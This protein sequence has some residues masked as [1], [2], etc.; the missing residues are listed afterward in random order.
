MSENGKKKKEEESGGEVG[1]W[2]V[3]FADMITLLLSFFVMLTTFSSYSKEELNKFSGIW[4]QLADYSVYTGKQGNDSFVRPADRYTDFTL[5]GSEKPTDHDP[6]V[7]SE[8][9]ASEWLASMSDAYSRRRVLRIP[10]TRLFWG[11]DT[12][13]TVLTGSGMQRMKLLAEFLRQVPCQVLIGNSI[14][15]RLSSVCKGSELDRPMA[16]LEYLRNSELIPSGRIGLTVCSP[17]TADAAGVEGVIEITLLA[18][19]QNK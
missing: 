15:S 10:A 18:E 14:A 4:A 5:Q 16:L 17:Q 3:S 11:L 13:G 1:L 8:P 2:Y 9:P 6:N 7:L 12:Q 19:K